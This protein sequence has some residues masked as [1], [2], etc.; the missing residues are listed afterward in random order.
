M[1][2]CESG[3]ITACTGVLHLPTQSGKT[4]SQAADKRVAK[5]I[6]QAGRQGGSGQ[7]SRTQVSDDL[8]T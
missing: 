3:G 6:G 8:Q 2:V 4:T 5:H 1:P 7:F